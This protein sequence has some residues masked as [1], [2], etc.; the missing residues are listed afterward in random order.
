MEK[1]HLFILLYLF[2]VLL[3]FTTALSVKFILG[4]WFYLTFG[5]LLLLL[6]I[7]TIFAFYMEFK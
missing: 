4:E 3:S 7:L 6:N 5:G 2:F 1:I